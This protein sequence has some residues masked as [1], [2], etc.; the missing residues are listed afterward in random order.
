MDKSKIK[1]F[2][3]KYAELDNEELAELVYRANELADEA[4]EALKEVVLSK[5]LKFEPQK[6][7]EV[8]EPATVDESELNKSLKKGG[9]SFFS[10]FFFI[11]L[12]IGPAQNLTKNMSTPYGFSVAWTAVTA[13]LLVAI[14]GFLGYKL[15]KLV[16][17]GIIDNESS[18][19]AQKVTKLQVT[20]LLLVVMFFIIFAA[21]AP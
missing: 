9:L 11:M 19:Y 8:I 3:S 21:T 1:F 13:G 18:N 12:F 5:G 14:P 7:I 2:T 16:V 4:R 20:L 6:P 10:K 15:G 17:D